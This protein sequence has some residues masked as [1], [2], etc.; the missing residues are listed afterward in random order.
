MVR[1]HEDVQDIV[2]EAF[3][4]AYR[5]MLNLKD[6]DKLGAWIRGIAL[7]LARQTIKKRE[8]DRKFQDHGIV[9]AV[10]DNHPSS[11]AQ[12][13]ENSKRVH[14]A[15]SNLSPERLEITALYYLYG[16][17][18]DEISSLCGKPAGTVKRILSEA[19]EQLKKE[20][21]QM[22]QEEFKEY[23]LTEEQR[24]RLQK[25][26]E[27]PRKEPNISVVK[28]DEN[29]PR[30]SS[31]AIAKTFLDDMAD[32]EQSCYAC[33]DYPHPHLADI[34]HVEAKAPIEVEGKSSVL[35]NTLRFNS[36]KAVKW[37]WKFY[38][39]ADS[40]ST[41]CL[42]RQDG[43]ANQ[44]LPDARKPKYGLL[45]SRNIQPGTN[46]NPNGEKDGIM[47]DV[48]LYEVSIG[49]K[50]F[51]CVRQFT[52]G[53][54]FKV[55]W[56]TTPV[57]DC[58]DEDFYLLDGRQLLHRFYRGVKYSQANPSISKNITYEYLAQSSVPI[59]DFL[60]D[61]YYLSYDLLPEYAI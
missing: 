53:G 37:L 40:N 6:S 14:S 10:D 19:R 33:Y 42:M 22:A 18:V 3:F 59:L 60:G 61:K 24:Q 16:K 41:Q 20:L 58:V 38:Y 23:M 44:P 49:R 21:L 43:P 46:V 34:C 56:S 45:R 54:K 4:I 51:K 9:R 2:Q 31:K 15:L 8:Q 28:L 36:E 57:A 17:K 32:G 11:L 27:F 30:I 26:P 50:S 39:C 25:I 7:N 5:D 47:T 35:I 48:S 52:G 1:N 13:Q 12:K 29:A 55:D